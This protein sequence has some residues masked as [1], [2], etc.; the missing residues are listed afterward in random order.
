MSHEDA[1]HYAKKHQNK[2]LDKKIA[3][4]L[5]KKSNNKTIS[6]AAIH[7]A[8]EVLGISPI[9]AGIQADLME[10]RLVKCSLGLFG[11]DPGKKKINKNMEISE[12]LNNELEKNSG[13]GTITCIKCWKIGRKLKIKRL[14]IASACENKG[15]KIKQ[16]QLGAF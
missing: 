8:A 6:C 13:N 7:A 12:L 15:I 1:G 5:K 14:D 4:V 16:C 10:L 3:S 11:Y 9:E 2:N